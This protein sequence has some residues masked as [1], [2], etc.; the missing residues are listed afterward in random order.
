MQ[1]EREH[2]PAAAAEP[3]VTVLPEDALPPPGETRR[4]VLH[5]RRALITHDRVDVRPARSAIVPPL[6][7]FGI[8]AL[9]VLGI[10]FGVVDNALPT[11]LLAFL[12]LL[13]LI[14]VPLSGITLVYAL[15]GA[16]VI[17]DRA[18]QSGVWQQGFLGMGIGTTELVPFWK[19]E[20]IVV[21]EAGAAEGVAGGRTEELSQW[22]AVLVKKSGKRL[23]IA[24]MTVPREFVRG[25]IGPVRELAAAV[26]ALT[27]A[28]LRVA[29]APIVAAA[30]TPLPAP[31]AGRRTVRPGAQRRTP[32]R[33][34]RRQNPRNG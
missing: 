19:V 25:G 15:F 31:P 24:G 6:F 30:T 12:L 9:C 22:E 34:H 3:A 23:P 28:P 17:F 21:S 33:A 7:G 20:S 18:K 32:R 16:N 10:I 11:V 14:L 26:A 27:D 13:A 5:R 1:Q 2:Q 4:I 29:D 8:G